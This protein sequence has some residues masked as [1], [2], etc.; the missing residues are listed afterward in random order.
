[1]NYIISQINRKIGL[2]QSLDKKAEL[3]TH[4]QAKLEFYL[5]YIL[6]YLWNKNFELISEEDKEYVIN[7]ILKP[8]IGSIIATSRTLDINS[9]LFGNKKLKSFTNSVYQY[10]NVRNEKIGHGFSF[11]DDIDNYLEIFEEL[12]EKIESSENNILTT[13]QDIVI[14]NSFQD[15]VYSG[16]LFKPNGA[17]YVAWSCPKEVNEFKIGSL[18][19]K[20]DE[21]GY[22]R[23]TPFVHLEN[24]NDFY[25]FSSIEE[26]L[27]GRVKYNQLIRSGKKVIE[28]DELATINIVND[29]N[30][31]KTSNGT[32]INHFTKN[33]KKYI[34][35]GVTNQVIKFLTKNNSSV[36]AT[37][38]GHGGI[39]KTAAIQNA[40][41][42]LANQERKKFDYIV[43]ISAKDR[44][45]NYYKGVIQEIK[46]NISSLNEIIQFINTL[47]F[48]DSNDEIDKI[49]NYDGQ[50]LIVIDDF[51]T[52]SKTEKSNITDFIKKLNINHHKI[53]LTTRSATL[54]TGEEIETN[55]LSEAQTIS[56]LIEAIKNEIPSHNIKKDL[57]GFKKHSGLIHKITSGRPLFILQFAILLAQKGS[58]EETLTVDIK[59]TEEAKNFLYD[60]I[61]DYLS[62]D[63][64][65]MFLGIN[66]LVNKEDLSGLTDNLKFILNKEENEEDFENALNELIK[67]KIIEIEDKDFF[68]VYSPEILKVMRFYYENKGREFDG[69]ISNRFN[70][71]SN[72]EKLETDSALLKVADSN[73]LVSSEDEVENQYRRI[74][75]RENAPMEIRIKALLNFA[76]Y[77][78][79][80]K[81]KID[82]T[83][84]LFDDY[85]HWFNRIPE[86]IIMHSR[87]SWAEGSNE[88]RYRATE[89]LKEFLARRPKIDEEVY[90]ELLGTLMTYSANI[91][92]NER[93]QIKEQRRFN[94]ISEKKYE[95][96]NKHQ[97]ERFWEL[98]KYPG[99]RLYEATKEMDLMNLTPKCRNFVLDGL[100]HFTEI[101]IRVN[102][103]E[104]GKEICKKVIKELPT[105]YHKAFQHKL[106]KIDFIDNG[107]K[108]KPTKNAESDLA[109]KL[110]QA[111]EKK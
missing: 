7:T 104:I 53:I 66:L 15:N 83:L 44:Y 6:G 48:D 55:E 17:D 50:L 11:E 100:T 65:N 86:F 63:A 64:K 95:T 56:F 19:I 110:K 1:M 47:V 87:Y 102:K 37:L 71:I 73:R 41:E 81:S 30:K 96:L 24:E 33:Y 42:I 69:D 99:S 75:K 58:L 61:Y 62:L 92:V 4:Y 76:N 91:L 88:R 26:K 78:F 94:E 9:E 70:L 39:G 82:K 10:P 45:Y 106:K 36:F 49:I 80:Q 60:R 3:K 89:I 22:N 14:V 97:R 40:C 101:C 67:L 51:E 18:Y 98:F 31:R 32:I 84:K 29:G 35:V 68:K 57:K 107:R 46:G 85:W 23:L 79:S 43:F 105:D 111:L 93:E 38:W 34:D 108:H 28:Y 12:I 54:I 77:L 27:T 16:I 8:S 109:M 13:E 90:L 74:I 21:F 25:I 103:R 5:N 72:N 59:S 52:F 20:S 2:L